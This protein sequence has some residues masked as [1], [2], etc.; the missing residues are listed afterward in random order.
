M[1]LHFQSY[2][3]TEIE[4]VIPDLARLRIKVFRDFPYLYDG[5]EDYESD[6]LA[7]YSR[8]PTAI[9]VAALDGDKIVGAATGMAMEDHDDDFARPLAEI[10]I[11]HSDVFYCAESVLLAE[12]R[13]QGAGHT[14]FDAREE[15]ARALGRTHSA[16]T[17]VLRPADHP[18]RPKGYRP[19]DGFW[20]KRGYSRLD[21]AV[22]SF[23]WTDIG[24]TE[25]TRKS[26]QYWMKDLR[27]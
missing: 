12:Y 7:T 23:E 16:F 13:G 1:T 10:G 26:L 9:V 3:G 19:L 5:N 14:F 20:R 21:G 27:A 4:S 11:D 15:H 17:S 2:L 24:A 6:Y 25:P 8:T 22:A 18:S